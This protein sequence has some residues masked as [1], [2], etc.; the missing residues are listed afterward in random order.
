MKIPMELER[1]IARSFYQ[2]NLTKD[3]ICKMYGMRPKTVQ[4]ILGKMKDEFVKPEQ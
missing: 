4:L 3:D 1:E 2:E